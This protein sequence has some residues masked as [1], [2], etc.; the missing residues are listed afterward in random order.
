MI[1]K[2]STQQIIIGS[3]LCFT[4][5]LRDHTQNLSILSRQKVF[6]YFC[7]ETKLLILLFFIYNSYTSL[8]VNSLHKKSML[9]NK[10][11]LIN[12]STAYKNKCKYFSL[13]SQREE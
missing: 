5:T 13:N 10:S 4:C 2:F 8:K 11:Q 1:L 12:N 7:N 9:N 3:V 6:N